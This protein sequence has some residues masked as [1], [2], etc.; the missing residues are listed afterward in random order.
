MND[1]LERLATI[2]E[3][4]KNA[5]PQH[6]YVAQLYQAGQDKILKK[7]GEEAVETVLAAKSRESDAIIHETADLWF[8]SLVM[9]AESGLR[10]EQVL[11]ELER[12]FG[13]SGLEEKANRG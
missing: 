9:L 8:H 10:P 2:L 6:S 7:L 4:R 12:R 5:D 1:T 11:R 13:L 3:E